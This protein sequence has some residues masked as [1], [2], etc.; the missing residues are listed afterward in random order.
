MK[1]AKLHVENSCQVSSLSNRKCWNP[2]SWDEIPGTRQDY[3][4]CC[5]SPMKSATFNC[6]WYKPREIAG[7]DE[8]GFEITSGGGSTLADALN[9]WKQSPGHNEVII[10]SNSWKYYKWRSIGCAVVIGQVAHCW[11]SKKADSSYRSQGEPSCGTGSSGGGSNYGGGSGSWGGGGSSGGSNDCFTLDVRGRSDAIE[12]TYRQSGTSGGKPAYSGPGRNW[13]YAYRFGSKTYWLI[14]K[15]KG[16]KSWARGYCSESN[17]LDCN[18]KWISG[19]KSDMQ[20]SSCGGRYEMVEDTDEDGLK[21]KEHMR[22]G[23][24]V[25]GSLAV[26]MICAI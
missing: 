17:V 8:D 20:W 13:L 12:G 23:W 18:G 6:I 21:S 14:S 7:F 22:I 25:G 5:Y 26:V 10:Q 2:H 3:K 1:V 15:S 11:F 16:S 9:G 24:I 19:Y 4:T